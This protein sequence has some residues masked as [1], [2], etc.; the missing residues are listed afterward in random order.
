MSRLM[1]T[2]AAP[3]LAESTG[4]PT[5]RAALLTSLSVS[6]SLW[7]HFTIMPSWMS[8]N[9]VIFSNDW[10]IKCSYQSGQNNGQRFWKQP[11]F[12]TNLSL[13]RALLNEKYNTRINHAWSYCCN[14]PCLNNIDI[15]IIALRTCD[16]LGVW[17]FNYITN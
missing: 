13:L 9:S 10:N 5:M 6:S 1:H 2:D 8:V 3:I 11:W 17:I 14:S 15:F 12:L 16:G 4:S 7:I